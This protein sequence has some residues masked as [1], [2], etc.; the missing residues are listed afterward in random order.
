MCSV[1]Q[2]IFGTIENGIDVT[3]YT[4]ERGD[5]SLQVIDYGATITSLK[6]RDTDVMLGFDNI[7]GYQSKTGGRNPYMGAIIGRVGNRIANAKFSLDG[8]DYTLAQNNGPNALHGG[9]EGFDKVMWKTTVIDQHKIVFSYISKDGEEGYPG[10]VLVNVTYTLDG[11]GGVRIDYSAMVTAPTPVNLTNHSYFNL[12]GH[13]SGAKGLEDH[14]VTMSCAAYTPVSDKLIPT[15]EI[16]TVQGTVFDLRNPTRLGDVLGKCPGGDNNGFDHNFVVTADSSDLNK[17]CRIEHPG[18]AIWLECRTDQ[19]GCQFYTGNFIPQD[20][21][22]VGKGGSV[23][24]KH[25]GFCLE[26]QIH[27]DAINQ[28]LFPTPVIRPGQHYKHTTLFKF[29][30]A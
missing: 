16:A 1:K 12:G 14:V 9:L 28:A 6:I 10:D 11:E 24:R 17:V 18:T 23:Y 15:G 19:P 20:H 4:L 26:T 3:R 29:G 21:S 2:D 22:L 30:V 13:S 27:P 25:G 5:I 7:E 8:K